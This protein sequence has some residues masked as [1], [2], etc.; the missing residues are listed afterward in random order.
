MKLEEFVSETLLD[1]TRGVKKAQRNAPQWIAPGNIEGK[2][3]VEPQMVTFDVSV[4]VSKEAGAGIQVWSIGELNA[5]GSSEQSNRIS[6]AMPVYFQAMI[7][8]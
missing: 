7:K 3:L 6:F 4:T 5:K 8:P 1:I 2:K